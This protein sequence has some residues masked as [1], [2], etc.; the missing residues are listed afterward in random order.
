MIQLT[1]GQK[2]ALLYEIDYNRKNCFLSSKTELLMKIAEAALKAEPLTIDMVQRGV[3]VYHAPP[4][5]ELKLPT[6]GLPDVSEESAEY[7]T[8]FAMG[9]ACYAKRVIELNTTVPEGGPEDA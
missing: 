5:V 4:V 2:K 7:R 3:P 8:G 9:C 6:D 1:E